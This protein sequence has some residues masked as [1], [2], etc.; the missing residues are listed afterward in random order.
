MPPTEYYLRC[1][2]DIYILNRVEVY[3]FHN[4]FVEN[5]TVKD[6]E[7]CQNAFPTPM[8]MIVCLFFFHSIKVAY[9]V[10]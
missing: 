9:H 3:S 7:F 10:Y 4:Q 8:Y 6:I 5:V 2:L 1:S